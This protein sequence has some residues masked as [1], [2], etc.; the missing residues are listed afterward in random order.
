MDE[1]VERR[2]TLEIKCVSPKADGGG[3]G[4]IFQLYKLDS[5][6]STESALGEDRLP[7]YRACLRR[8]ASREA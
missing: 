6:T 8:S 7:L 2:G 3:T 4:D 1:A 5:W